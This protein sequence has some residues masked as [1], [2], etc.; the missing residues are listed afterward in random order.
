[1]LKLKEK[2]TKTLFFQEIFL[3]SLQKISSTNYHIILIK[4]LLQEIIF[5]GDTKR[6][7]VSKLLH[8]SL[9]V[10]TDYTVKIN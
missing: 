3:I 6:A 7:L 9:K 2:L 8:N 10:I 5:Y 4:L 1:M